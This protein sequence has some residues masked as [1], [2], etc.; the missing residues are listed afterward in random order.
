MYLKLIVFNNKVMCK[1][2]LYLARCRW[3]DSRDVEPLAHRYTGS[4]TPPLVRC[5][6][7][8]YSCIDSGYWMHFTWCF[9]SSHMSVISSDRRSTPRLSVACDSDKR[10]DSRSC[11]VISVEESYVCVFARNRNLLDCVLTWRLVWLLCPW[12]C[13]WAVFPVWGNIE[14]ADGDSYDS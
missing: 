1:H 8:V 14:K 10:S 2:S 7:V 6:V 13:H 5:P 11:M 9:C 3:K 12:R 4:C